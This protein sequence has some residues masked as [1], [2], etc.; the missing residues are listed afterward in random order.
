MKE[1][2]DLFRDPFSMVPQ[3]SVP[4]V[5]VEPID[6]Q[7]FA[8][9][10]TTPRVSAATLLQSSNTSKCGDSMDH[11]LKVAFLFGSIHTCV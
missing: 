2:G 1:L 5:V 9:L 8:A 11:T 10:N 3:D 4:V 6:L 7:C